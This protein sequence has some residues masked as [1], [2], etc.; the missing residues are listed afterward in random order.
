MSDPT[1][2]HIT[3]AD[4]LQTATHTGPIWSHTSE[5]LNLNLLVFNPGEV[6]ATHTNNAV[7]VFGIVVEGQAELTFAGE[8][9]ILQS[10]DTFLIPRGTERTLRVLDK[11]FAYISC[12]QRRGGIMPTFPNQ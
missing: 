6:I 3:P 5:Q 1:M 11:R 10:G 2:I 4:M 8:T 9:Y 7:D 12:H